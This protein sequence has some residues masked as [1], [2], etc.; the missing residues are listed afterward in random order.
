MGTQTVAII[1][2][3]DDEM[4]RIMTEKW[5][6]EESMDQLTMHYPDGLT[7]AL[8]ES[9]ANLFDD[10]FRNLFFHISYGISEDLNSRAL[11]GCNLFSF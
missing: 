3:A 10:L 1:L 6:N 8:P 4:V 2:M 11:F 5:K 7:A 9:N